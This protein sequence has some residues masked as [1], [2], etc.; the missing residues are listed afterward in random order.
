MLEKTNKNCVGIIIPFYGGNQYLIK[1][2]DSI[3][4]NQSEFSF[5]IIIVDNSRADEKVDKSYTSVYEGI[6]VL[7]AREGIGYGA[8]CNIGFAYLKNREF[9]YAVVINQDGYLEKNTIS[10]LINEIK[11]NNE[12]SATMPLSVGY[13]NNIVEPFFISV[14]LTKLNLLISDLFGSEVKK[15]YKIDDL[16]GACFAI[17]ISTIAKFNFVFDKLFHM[18]Y[19]DQD[20]YKRLKSNGHSVFFIPT[21]V[22]HHNHSHTDPNLQTLRML[23]GKRTSHHVF[24]LLHRPAGLTRVF[25]GWLILSL[26]NIVIQLLTFNLKEL[27]VEFM[28]C[29]KCIMLFPDII[30]RRK[31]S[32][33][34]II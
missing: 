8:A 32:S 16:C 18:Y 26:R 13:D 17:R 2:L 21:A 3:F 31:R 10:L 7:D 4:N 24:S 20:L 19:E 27:T 14:Y 23:I 34:K 33:K 9:E 25:I 15:S 5:L 29:L 22:F 6:V 1:L 11:S 28:S 30:K 12:C